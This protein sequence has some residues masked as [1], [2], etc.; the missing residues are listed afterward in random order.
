VGQAVLSRPSAAVIGAGIFGVTAALALGAAGADVTLYESAG[1][2]LTGATARNVF[3]LHRGYHYPRDAATAT[4]ARDGY[5]SFT[6]MFAAAL[7]PPVPHY[8]AIAAQGSLTTPEQFAEHCAALGLRATPARVPGAVPGSLAAC[9]RV[10]E[11]YYDAGLLRQLCADRLARS[12]VKVELGFTLGAAA[13]GAAH[14]VVVVAAYAALNQVLADL[15][16]PL[17]RLQYETCEVALVRAPRLRRLSLVVMDGPFCSVAPYRDGLHLLYDVQHSV[18]AR[19]V[20][21]APAGTWW[22]AARFPAILA[23]AR[24]FVSGLDDARHAGS[25]FAD[26]VVLSGAEATDARPTQVA[27]VTPWVLSVLSG[28]VCTSADAG[29]L[30]AAQV[31]AK[32]GMRVPA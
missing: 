15:G 30:A 9:F 32:L 31:A 14:D 16:C 21:H 1:D 19:T 11:S 5:E 20:G 18:H 25:L 7:A 24:R 4:A 29:R 17:T 26:R 27:W 2:I 3:R 8:Y 12:R 6:A 28:K 23:S 13:I 10:D 22:G